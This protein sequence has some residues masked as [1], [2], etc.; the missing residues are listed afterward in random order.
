MNSMATVSAT[1]SDSIPRTANLLAC[2]Q[3]WRV[4]FL[5]GNQEKYYRQIYGKAASQRLATSSNNPICC[6]VEESSI[7]TSTMYFPEPPTRRNIKVNASER[8]KQTMIATDQ[9]SLSQ[10][11]GFKPNRKI[12]ILDDPFLF[13]VNERANLSEDSGIDN[14]Q[15]GKLIPIFE[16]K[17]RHPIEIDMNSDHCNELKNNESELLILHM[18]EKYSSAYSTAT[19]NSRINEIDE[20]CIGNK[21][22]FNHSISSMYDQLTQTN[23]TSPTY[24]Q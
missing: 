1:V 9:S 3:W 4:C 7:K 16:S 13:G 20:Q 5:H 24:K 15:N 19:K 12:T 10:S 22:H 8:L 23:T 11:E 14:A 18:R 17:Q 2:K 21:S 6:G